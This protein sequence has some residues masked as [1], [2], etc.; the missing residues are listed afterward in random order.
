MNWEW[1]EK[2]IAQGHGV[3]W[4]NH[5]RAWLIIRKG[6]S[7]NC[8]LQIYGAVPGSRRP[9]N[10]LSLTEYVGALAL[11][12]LGVGDILEQCPLWPHAQSSA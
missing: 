2:Q 1:I 10:F 5:Y 8:S 3:G 6:A 7:S 4:E 12:F 11:K 9:F